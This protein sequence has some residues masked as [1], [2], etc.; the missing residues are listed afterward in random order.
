[1]EEQKITSSYINLYK[2]FLIIGGVISA[3]TPVF[4]IFNYADSVDKRIALQEQAHVMI[5]GRID[6]LEQRLNRDNDQ[7]NRQL[8]DLDNKIIGIYNI[9][10]IEKGEIS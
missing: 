3:L 7:Q 8:D 1:M 2:I 10:S 9:L 5:N 4:Y 6:N